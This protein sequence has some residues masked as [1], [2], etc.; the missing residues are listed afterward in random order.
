MKKI[1]SLMI[2][3]LMLILPLNA[4][5]KIKIES[6][7][8]KGWNPELK[9][10][11]YTLNTEIKISANVESV[12]DSYGKKIKSIAKDKSITF[13]AVNN[14]IKMN[15]EILSEEIELRPQNEKELSLMRTSINDKEYFGG[16]KLIAKKNNLLV[17]NIVPVE[18]YLRAVLPKEMS[19]SWN[20]DALKAQAVAART[21]ALKNRK[22]HQNEGYDLCS[23][24]HCQ[25]FDGVEMLNERTD[26]AIYSTFGEVIYYK[27]KLIEASFHTDSG[28]ITEN[29]VDVWETDYPYLRAVTEIE[30]KTMEW[31]EYFTTE[32]F[33]KRLNENGY[34]IGDVKFIKLT[35]LEIGKVKRD[36]SSSGRVK[37]ITIVGS[38]DEIKLSGNDMRT[39]FGLKSTLFDVSMNTEGFKF[40]GYG[41]GHG[42]GMSQY[43]ALNLAEHGYDYE[44]ILNHYYKG[45]EIKRL[46]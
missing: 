32:E 7:Q 28:G 6:N 45:T 35:D 16:L 33:N 31:T 13:S 30:N 12:I 2:L 21:F 37:E 27:D 5:S 46:Y 41:W 20:K 38:S 9:I 29:A 11:L 17:I 15:E 43:G 14:K 40:K 25:S 39:I 1:I 18:E 34:K 23:T 3:I 19:P 44:K 8:P 26:E 42:V 36:R 4:E 24:V 22:R 10:G